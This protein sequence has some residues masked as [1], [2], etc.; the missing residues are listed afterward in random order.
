[1]SKNIGGP[2]KAPRETVL[3]EEAAPGKR[4]RDKGENVSR[5]VTQ[6]HGENMGERR[7][8]QL[9]RLAHVSNWMGIRKCPMKYCG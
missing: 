6:A 1:M 8:N 4:G 9:Q 2:K 5:C 7:R 3:R